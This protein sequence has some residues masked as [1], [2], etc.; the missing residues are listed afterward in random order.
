MEQT[1]IKSRDHSTR[2]GEWTTPPRLTKYNQLIEAIKSKSAANSTSLR[3]PH[4]T[5]LTG[6]ASTGPPTT[7]S[8][9]Y[10]SLHWR[11]RRKHWQH[12][13]V[14]GSNDNMQTLSTWRTS[15]SRRLVTKLDV[16]GP[17]HLH[18]ST[19]LTFPKSNA[20][21]FGSQPLKN[22]GSDPTKETAPKKSYRHCHLLYRWIYHHH[23]R[24]RRRRHHHHHQQ[25]QQHQHQQTTN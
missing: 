13:L 11:S 16:P 8:K 4:L 18:K 24:H 6:C 15:A 9:L 1:K 17:S 20:P 2:G 7:T 21:Q 19:Q 5:N 12:T 22:T 25:Q 3:S 14:Q 23:H 10:H